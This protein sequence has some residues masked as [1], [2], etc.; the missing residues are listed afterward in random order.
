MLKLDASSGKITCPIGDTGLLLVTLK[1]KEGASPF[2]EDAV[3][4]FKVCGEK[5]VEPLIVKVSKLIGNAA[6]IWLSST[7]TQ[8]LPKGGAYRWNARI[9]TV[10][11][12]DKG[13]GVSAAS[14]G[15]E[16]HSPFAFGGSLPAF[17]AKFVP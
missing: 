5:S 7:D 9:V 10:P 4:E 12:Y 2:P 11:Q 16:V 14:A 1:L 15:A 17:E 6:A 3:V 13:G 8:K